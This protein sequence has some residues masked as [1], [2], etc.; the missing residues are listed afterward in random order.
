MHEKDHQEVKEVIKTTLELLFTPANS[1]IN[2]TL[3]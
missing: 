2:S 1:V 3:C